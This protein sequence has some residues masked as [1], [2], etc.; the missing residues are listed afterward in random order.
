MAM[1]SRVALP[2]TTGKLQR[3]RQK[4]V[5]AIREEIAV[6]GRFSAETVTQRAGSSTATFYN[7][8]ATKDDALTA[9]YE[10][11]MG[12]LVEMVNEKCHIER[13]LD[14][15]LR[16]LVDSWVLRSAE[17]FCLN[18]PLFRVAQAAIE[19]SKPMRDVF[20]QHE[21]T[22][23]EMYRRFIERGQAAS[24]IRPGDPEAMAQMITVVSESWTHPLVQRL[25]PGSA[26]HQELTESVVRMLSPDNS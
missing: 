11:L 5:H 15:G 7:H 22:V 19:R 21:A 3:T 25:E 4:L 24:L 16:E 6:S 9:A 8:F 18:A 17:F 2:F 23:I 10:Q 1:E 12:E 14:I 13:L 26:L 20:R